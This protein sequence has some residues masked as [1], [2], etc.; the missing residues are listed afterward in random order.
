M[1]RHE[2]EPSAIKEPEKRIL[3]EN[4][5]PEF[6]NVTETNEFTTRCY[7]LITPKDI[8]KA[9]KDVIEAFKASKGRNE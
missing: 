1:S 9:P 8:L 6:F 3:A 4:L 7:T 5:F 2:S